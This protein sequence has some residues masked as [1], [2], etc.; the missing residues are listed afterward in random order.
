[1]S[2]AVALVVC[3]N[4]AGLGTFLIGKPGCVR[5]STSIWLFSS[6]ERTLVGPCPAD[7]DRDRRY[8]APSRTKC[9][10]FDSLKASP[11]ARLGPVRLPDPARQ[12]RRPTGHLADAPDVSPP[13]A[14]R[15]GLPM[16]SP[17]RSPGALSGGLQV[18]VAFSSR[19]SPAMPLWQGK[20]LLPAP[21]RHRYFWRTQPGKSHRADPVSDGNTIRARP[22]QLHGGSPIFGLPRNLP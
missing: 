6:T 19:R 5:S 7:R 11:G 3:V 16:H 1:M 8:R 2:S 13:P 9:S 20:A 4:G 15:Q 17:A 21:H 14:S 22:N 12:M 10:S 18:P